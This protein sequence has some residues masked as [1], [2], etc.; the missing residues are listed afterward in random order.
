M[1]RNFIE[2]LRIGYKYPYPQAVE[3]K[4]GSNGLINEDFEC[5]RLEL[6]AKGNGMLEGHPVEYMDVRIYITEK[7]NKE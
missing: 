6:R 4:L 2:N 1:K 5:S 3:P 7:G